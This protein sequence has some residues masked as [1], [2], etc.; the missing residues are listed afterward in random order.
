MLP[1]SAASLATRR[2]LAVSWTTSSINTQ[3]HGSNT[4]TPASEGESRLIARTAVPMCN[5][6][7]RAS[8]SNPPSPPAS[9]ASVGT[10]ITNN[11]RMTTAPS[12]STLSV[13]LS[14]SLSIT[15]PVTMVPS[16]VN[17]SYE[18][19]GRESPTLSPASSISTSTG[20]APSRGIATR[21]DSTP[22]TER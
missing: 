2:V 8:S 1:G 16:T 5:A 11:V 17:N 3:L 9:E 22:L 7:S 20:A 19:M 4:V 12:H 6:P 15:K 18:S 13:T 21:L 10:S 14:W